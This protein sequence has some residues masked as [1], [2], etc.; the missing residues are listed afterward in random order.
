[1]ILGAVPEISKILELIYQTVFAFGNETKWQ[2]DITAV[3]IKNG[4]LDLRRSPTSVTL[5][6]SPHRAGRGSADFNS[7]S[8]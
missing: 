6:A 2:D 1:M 5:R 8:K 3:V 4:F 7:A